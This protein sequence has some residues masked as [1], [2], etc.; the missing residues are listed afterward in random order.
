M[1]FEIE[2]MP[3][4]WEHLQ[5]FSARDRT[6]LLAEIDIQLRYEPHVE[7]RNRKPLREN[8]LADWE[9]RVEKFRVFYDIE[10]NHV[11]IV[12]IIAIGVKEGNHLFIG[13]KRFE[14]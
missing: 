6:T 13:G 9:L 11:R 1:A 5:N 2:F 3:D 7:T 10:D 14:L 4:A 12:F 8:T